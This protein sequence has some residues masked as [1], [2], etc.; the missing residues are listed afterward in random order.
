MN[1]KVSRKDGSGA[2]GLHSAG[3]ASCRV[4]ELPQ[5]PPGRPKSEGLHFLPMAG[6]LGLDDF[7]LHAMWSLCL[8]EANLG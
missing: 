5:I 7:G 6:P 4:H 8:Q 1:L 2:G 3:S